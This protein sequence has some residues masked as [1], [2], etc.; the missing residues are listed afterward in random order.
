MLHTRV[1]VS[2]CLGLVAVLMAFATME[3]DFYLAG[4]AAG[5]LVVAAFFAAL[6]QLLVLLTNI[7]QSLNE[8][9][10]DLHKG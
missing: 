1:T 10:A 4:I 5:V 6:D 7:R 2:L 9:K 3:Q 8:L